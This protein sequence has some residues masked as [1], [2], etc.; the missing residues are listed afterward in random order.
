MGAFSSFRNV[1]STLMLSVFAANVTLAQNSADTSNKLTVTAQLRPR[2][3]LRHGA[4]RPL[5]INEKPA[6]LI[7]QRGRITLN[8]QHKGILSLQLSPQHINIWGQEALTQSTGTNN[9][10]AF[11][12]AWAKL[13]VSSSALLQIGRQVISLDDE[14]F[15]GA[16]DWAQGGR[17]HDAVSFQFRRDKL[18]LSVHAAFNQNYAALYDNNLSNISGSLFSSKGATPYKWMQNAWLKYDWDKQSSFSLLINNLG[19]QNAENN[20]DDNAKTYFTQTIGANYFH[21]GSKWKY[22]ASAYYQGGKNPQGI[23]TNAYLVAANMERALTTQW[24]LALGGDLLSGNN[25][26]GTLQKDNHAFVP[27][28]G[29][30]H[31]FYGSM[32]YYYSGNA[33]KNTGLGDAYLKAR[34]RSNARWMLALT[35]HQF[36]SPVSLK[37]GTNEL[38]GNLGQEFDLDFNYNIHP[39]LGLSGGY[40]LYAVTPS[41]EFL[42]GIT[43]S[44]PLQHWTWCTLNVNADILKLKF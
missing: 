11:F 15:F 26:D 18:E 22:S 41:T 8:F 34:Y 16:L 5:A 10:L 21:A 19:F 37:E 27:Y 3:E 14:R 20:A 28:F 9:G 31:K 23:R 42:K 1:F 38:S 36:V 30:N 29:T 44:N 40:S 25:A 43:S 39:Y 17:A 4:F 6:F 35:V 13:R 32:D 2:A 7:S 12:E 33:H 24:S